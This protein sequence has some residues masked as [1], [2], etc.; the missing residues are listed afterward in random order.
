MLNYFIFK[1]IYCILLIFLW[2]C[3]ITKYR[4]F[5]IAKSIFHSSMQDW[6]NLHALLRHFQYFLL[7]FRILIRLQ[8][9][10]RAVLKWRKL[11]HVVYSKAV[12]PM[13]NFALWLQL[14]Q[15]F[16]THI[17]KANLIPLYSDTLFLSS[18]LILWSM[19]LL[20]TTCYNFF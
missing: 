2:Q 16:I 14:W 15:I 4:N 5:S 1:F 20:V 3:L 17:D 18:T 8:I 6:L 12:L 9:F 7:F 19:N 11:V 10:Q 13:M